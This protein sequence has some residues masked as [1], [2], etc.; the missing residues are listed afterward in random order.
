MTNLI[1]E[2]LISKSKTYPTMVGYVILNIS[3]WWRSKFAKSQNLA[4]LTTVI[5]SR[6]A[7]T[8]TGWHYYVCFA[9]NLTLRS[10]NGAA[11]RAGGV[12]GLQHLVLWKGTSKTLR[13]PRVLQFYRVTTSNTPP[14]IFQSCP[15]LQ[16]TL[17]ISKDRI[18]LLCVSLFVAKLRGVISERGTRHVT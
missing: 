4:T 10:R 14:A 16:V 6:S 18:H 11:R 5:S 2:L 17:E 3:T 15:F 12:A 7:K 9:R 1:C 8:H 13:S